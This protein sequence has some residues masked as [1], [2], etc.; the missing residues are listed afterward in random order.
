MFVVFYNMILK[1]K[2]ME[3]VVLNHDYNSLYG[4]SFCMYAMICMDIY[5]LEGI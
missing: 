4:H 5:Y 1:H 2:F 3:W